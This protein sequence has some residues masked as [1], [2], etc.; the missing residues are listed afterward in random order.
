MFSHSSPRS[1]VASHFVSFYKTLSESSQY[2]YKSFVQVGNLSTVTSSSSLYYNNAVI[3][4]VIED[5]ST[6]DQCIQKQCD[7]YAS[8]GVRFV[9]YVDVEVNPAFYEQI[10]MRG[11]QDV[12][13]FQGV[14]GNLGK[15]PQLNM[16][17]H[18]TLVCV[19]TDEQMQHYNKLTST[20]FGSDSIEIPL[21]QSNTY[22]FLAYVDN[23]PVSAVSLYIEGDLVSFWNGV[24]LL[25]YRKKGLSTALRCYAL[26]LA[27]SKGCTTG[28]SYLMAT[29]GAVGICKKILGYETHWEYRTFVSP[30]IS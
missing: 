28:I 19:E 18:C 23:K 1:V 9:W 30:P 5:N 13:V 16:A 17:D 7:H 21:L 29:S 25:E 2:P 26:Q 3:D 10:T 11:F 6:W 8:L 20:V 4:R 12:G 22:H 27:T 14:M 15:L 24:T